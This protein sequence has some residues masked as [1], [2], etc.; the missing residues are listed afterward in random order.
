[1]TWCR[2]VIS[3]LGAI[4]GAYMASP[5]FPLSAAD[6]ML[7]ALLALLSFG[8]TFAILFT[9]PVYGAGF[10]R[11]NRVRPPRGRCF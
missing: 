1:M 10:I 11:G 6:W 3:L 4:I 8:L 7:A 2:L 5:R 9:E